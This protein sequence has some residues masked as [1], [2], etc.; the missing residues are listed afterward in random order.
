M[1]EPPDV[2]QVGTVGDL[3]YVNACRAYIHALEVAALSPPRTS[4]EVS[5]T[6]QLLL[7]VVN[8]DDAPPPPIKV[9]EVKAARSLASDI[10]QRGAKLYDLLSTEVSERYL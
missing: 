10:T 1:K 5:S 4:S 7:Q 3:C 2:D 6:D 8:A 9:Q